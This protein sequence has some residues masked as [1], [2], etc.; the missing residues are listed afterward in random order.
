MKS[1]ESFFASFQKAG[2]LKPASWTPSGGGGPYTANVRCARPTPRFSTARRR[3]DYEIEY[4]T[5]P[6]ARPQGR[7]GHGR[8]RSEPATRCAQPPTKILDG[9]VSRAELKK[10]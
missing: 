7:R 1:S 9:T 3:G 2:F 4:V 8:R 6:A 5:E 10:A